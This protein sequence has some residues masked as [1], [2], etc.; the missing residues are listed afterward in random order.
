MSAPA[1]REGPTG[2]DLAPGHHDAVVVDAHWRTDTDPQVLELSLAL[3]T[4][5][6]RGEVVEVG[7]ASG[8][9]ALARALAS[10]G[11]APPEAGDDTGEATTAGVLGMPCTLVLARDAAGNLGYA[12]EP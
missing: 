5:T 6:L 1:S 9:T 2:R 3:V 12:L 4:G 7:F 8:G 11:V 10:L